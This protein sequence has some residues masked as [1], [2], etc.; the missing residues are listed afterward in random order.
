MDTARVVRILGEDGE[1]GSAMIDPQAPKASQTQ[2]DGMGNIQTIYNLGVGKY[3]VTASVGPSY[4]TKRAE[5]SDMMLQVMQNQPELMQTIG[6]LIFKSF[7]WPMADKISDRLKKMLP[8]QLQE[9]EDG[10]PAIPAQVQAAMAQI[11]QQH[12]E[13]DQKA[14]ALSQAEQEID[15]KSMDVQRKQV[16]VF[17]QESRVKTDAIKLELEKHAA[18]LTLREQQ[19]GQG[20]T[21]QI[22]IAKAQLD[23]QTKLEIAK[24]KQETDLQI[25]L[26]QAEDSEDVNA[27][28]ENMAALVDSLQENVAKLMSSHQ[29]LAANVAKPKTSKAKA[30]KQADGSWELIRQD[31]I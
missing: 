17:V 7:D 21:S 29:E 18:E 19:M 6:D 10:Q 13:L 25:A 2:D 28:N 1:S 22:D 3:D 4:G 15:K 27:G 9:P 30:V 20:D 24:I 23:A 8:P 16:E 11:Q 26:L 31:G 5:Q 12:Q 14:Q